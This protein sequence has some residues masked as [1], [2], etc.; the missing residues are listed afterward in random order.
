MCK[1]TQN[2]K[3][4]VLSHPLGYLGVTSMARWKARGVFDFLLVLIELL[5][6]AITIEA[7]WA[8]I[9]RNRCVWR[10]GHFQRKFQE[11]TDV[12][13]ADLSHENFKSS[14]VRRW[15]LSRLSSRFGAKSS[16]ERKP[17]WLP[18]LIIWSVDQLMY[19]SNTLLHAVSCHVSWVIAWRLNWGINHSC[20]CY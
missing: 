20:L 15:W 11:E 10:G 14:W 2:V 12:Q 8:D 19:L 18:G 16:R 5:S 17:K 9:G 6:L 4:L 3:I 7:L 1:A 13:V